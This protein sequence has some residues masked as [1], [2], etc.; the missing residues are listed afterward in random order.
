M[1]LLEKLIRLLQVQLMI[2]K[3]NLLIGQKLMPTEELKEKKTK[4]RFFFF[5]RKQKKA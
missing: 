3:Y 5:K 2:K 4:K 1:L